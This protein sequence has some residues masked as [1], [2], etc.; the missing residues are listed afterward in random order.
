MKVLFLNHS[1]Q[2]CGVYQYGKRL[3]DILQKK[4]EYTYVEIENVEDYRNSIVKYSPDKILY[5]YHQ[6]TMPWLNKDNIQHDVTN[7]G[8]PHESPEHLFDIVCDIDPNA[9]ESATR[10]SI[11]RPIYENVDTLLENYQPSPSIKAFI[12]YSEEGVPVFGSFGF[13]FL[14]KGFYRLIQLIDATYDSAIIKLIIPGAH[15][16]DN[17]EYTKYQMKQIC[18]S[19]PRKSS[20]KLLITHE[21]VSNEDILLF[22]KSN[23]MNLFL[24][25][26]LDGRSISSTIDYALSVNTPLA[27]SDSNM[28]RHIYSDEICVYKTQIRDCMKQSR[29]HCNSF[30]EKYSHDTL[31]EKMDKICRIN[32][33][34]I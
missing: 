16:D 28:F 5:N 7:I 4:G 18:E 34:T 9:S 10:F 2:Q 6:S 19:I 15:F 22:L 27:I 8:I 21:F 1:K 3:Y 11:P 20:I 30:L 23:T 29:V 12:D 13:G 33:K 25:D 32:L 14:N 24:Y 17:R 31:I 26:K